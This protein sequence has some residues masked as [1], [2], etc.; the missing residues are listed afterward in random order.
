MEIN[1]PDQKFDV[2]VSTFCLQWTTDKL[3]VFKAM[4]AHYR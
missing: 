2:I 4:A 3:K 1:V